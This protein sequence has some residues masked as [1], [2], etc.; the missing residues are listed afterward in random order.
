MKYTIKITQIHFMK[1]FNK[2]IKVITIIGTRPEIIRLSEVIK[3]NDKLFDHKIIFTNQNFSK[4]LSEI[5]FRDFNIRKPDY[6]FKIQNN[7]IGQFYGDVLINSEKIFL[8]ERPDAIVILG[9]TNSCISALIAKRMSIPVF[10]LEA[11]NRSFDNNVPEELN[12]KIAD[13]ISDFNL[14]YTNYAKLNL[15]SEGFDKRRIFI[16]GSPLNE[17]L[18]KNKK[19]IFSSKILKQLKLKKNKY[20]L[21]SLH[22]EENVENKKKLDIL[23]STILKIQKIY[24]YKIVI[25]NHPRFDRKN[26]V[27]LTNKNIIIK[28]PFGFFDYIKLQK[29]AYCTIS[30]SGTI[31]E[32]SAIC[33]FPAVCIRDSI[34]RPESLDAGS[35]ILSGV[36]EENILNSIIMIKKIFKSPN[37][38]P[39]DYK[40]EDTSLRVA[41]LIQGLTN[42]KNK[43]LN[44]NI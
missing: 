38:C 39:E 32:E 27:L 9:D 29:N 33:N 24:N 23:I 41:R 34:E 31:S 10:H 28:K 44:I 40:I 18:K 19:L 8:K 16:I 36:H 21:V 4:E 22:R 13:N 1:K 15:I 2:K 17:V 3:I 14:A 20:F 42:L 11:G 37:N 12:R 7:S 26:K 30:D 43:W 25:T 5:F 35:L 6:H